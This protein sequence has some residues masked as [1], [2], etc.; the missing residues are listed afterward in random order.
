VRPALSRGA[1]HEAN[2]VSRPALPAGFV[3]RRVLSAA[4]VPSAS[5]SPY[6]P[7]NPAVRAP[8]RIVPSWASSQVG[9]RRSR[10]GRQTAKGACL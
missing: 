7:A 2:P 5:S 1:A 9:R 6:P 10:R 4:G 8:P 3:F